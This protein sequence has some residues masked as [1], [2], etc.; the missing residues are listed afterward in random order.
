MTRAKFIEELQKVLI[1]AIFEK[2]GKSVVL[3]FGN[4][5]DDD[6]EYILASILVNNGCVA[7]SSNC[8]W[9]G[10]AFAMDPWETKIYM[11]SQGWDYILNIFLDEVLKVQKWDN[12]EEQLIFEKAPYQSGTF[13]VKKDLPEIDDEDIF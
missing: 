5:D 11:T 4:K 13:Y 12:L 3:D 2:K 9:N 7:M 6:D 1:E 10:C 8:R